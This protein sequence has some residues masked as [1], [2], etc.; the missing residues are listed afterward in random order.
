MSDFSAGVFT[1][2]KNKDKVYPFLTEGELFIQYNE[3]WV[4]KL[5]PLD[6][7]DDFQPQ[8]IALSKTTPLLHIINAE[9]HGFCIR[10]LHNGD[11]TFKFEV[12]FNAEG[13][14]A[15]EI[16]EEMFGEEWFLDF[17]KAEERYKKVNEEAA[18]RLSTQ[19]VPDIYFANIDEENLK[20]FQIFGF[21]EKVLQKV[22][23]VLTVES[24]VKD[25]YEMVYALL[26][27]IGF[28]QFS[29]VAHNYERILPNESS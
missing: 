15:H 4:G 24:F 8:T 11:I 7:N 9:D 21:D 14:L 20:A 3:K 16:G 12:P 1:L 13:E 27:S 19:G 10:I 25:R 28:T 2:S 6:M 17:E 5:S 26:D 29:Y 18:K 23:Q 22:Q